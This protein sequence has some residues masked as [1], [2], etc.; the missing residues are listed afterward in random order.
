MAPSTQEW[1]PLAN[2]SSTYNETTKEGH[3]GPV[4]IR[5]GSKLP[6]RIL[7]FGQPNDLVQADL[8]SMTEERI[9]MLGGSQ[10]SPACT[11]CFRGVKAHRLPFPLEQGSKV[12]RSPGRFSQEHRPAFLPEATFQ[13]GLV[14][15]VS[16]MNGMNIFDHRNYMVSQLSKF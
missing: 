10:T 2:R 4:K 7:I 6:N 13:I 15:L 14:G 1:E 16:V 9:R 11:A 5:R 8:D 3:W 12:E